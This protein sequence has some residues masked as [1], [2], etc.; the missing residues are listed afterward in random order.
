ME[1]TGIMIRAGFWLTSAIVLGVSLGSGWAQE[2]AV[3]SDPQRLNPI[4]TVKLSGLKSFVERPL[5]TP[6][7]R[8]ALVEEKTQVESEAPAETGPEFLLL[9]V[10]SGPEGSVARITTDDG[11]ERHSLREGETID[12]WQLQAVDSSSVTLSRKGESVVLTIFKGTAP[13]MGD[14]SEP[15]DTGPGIVF[16]AEDGSQDSDTKPDVRVIDPN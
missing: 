15:A 4:D 14:E 9:G 12:G 1:G 16:D 2:N 13:T 5:F 8:P 10:T 11:A 6:A 3:R 7:R